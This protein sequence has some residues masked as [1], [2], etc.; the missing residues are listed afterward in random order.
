MGRANRGERRRNT[1]E[2]N[3]EKKQRTFSS[4]RTSYVCVELY[5]IKAKNSSLTNRS[6][7]ANYE[8]YNK[9]F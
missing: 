3:K 4:N 5:K 8:I 2:K 9:Q 7:Y 1:N 6:W